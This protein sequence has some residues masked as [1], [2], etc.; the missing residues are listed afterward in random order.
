[1]SAAT[2]SLPIKDGSATSK[3]S[4]GLILFSVRAE[5]GIARVVALCICFMTLVQ[6]ASGFSSI[7]SYSRSQVIVYRFGHF[8]FEQIAEKP[9]IVPSLSMLQCRKIEEICARPT[10]A[11]VLGALVRPQST[12]H[13][14]LRIPPPSSE[15]D[16]QS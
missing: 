13:V 7:S 1:M 4:P 6:L 10:P 12:T 5:K 2:R 15:D 14:R 9:S 3:I 11:P 8:P 16:H